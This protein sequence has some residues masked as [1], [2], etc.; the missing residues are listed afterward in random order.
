M[1]KKYLLGTTS[2]VAATVLAGG[3]A[4]AE[5]QPLN[6]QLGGFYHFDLHLYDE[7]VE[8]GADNHGMVTNQ[9]AEVNFNMRGELD[10]GMNQARA[11]AGS[12]TIKTHNGMIVGGWN[13]GNSAAVCG[14]ATVTS[15][16]TSELANP[17]DLFNLGYIY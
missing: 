5:A 2:L 12:T 6:I 17:G 15:G 3:N 8:G 14:G 7:D 1:D 13:G 11:F 4:L 9:D 10:N 16:C